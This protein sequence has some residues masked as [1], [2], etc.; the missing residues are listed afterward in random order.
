MFIVV[1]FGLTSLHSAVQFHIC[2]CASGLLYVHSI[3]VTKITYLLTYILT[4]LYRYR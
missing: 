3:R 4:Y 1:V 2:V